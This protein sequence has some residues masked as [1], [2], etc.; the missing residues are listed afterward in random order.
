MLASL[1]E[2]K[3]ATWFDLGLFLDRLREDGPGSACRAPAELRAFKQDIASG[4]GLLTFD[5]GID[6]VSMEIVKYAEALRL[7][8]GN[9]KIHY[10]AGHFEDF[11]DHVI[12]PTDTWHTIESMRGLAGLPASDRARGPGRTRS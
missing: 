6:G 4:V 9:P 3:V 8:L 11:L 1:R 7:F 5:F 10:I 12:A 2:E